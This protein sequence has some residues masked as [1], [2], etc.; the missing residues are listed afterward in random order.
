M[1]RA[2][3]YLVLVSV[4][5]LFIAASTPIT[6]CGGSGGGGPSGLDEDLCDLFSFSNNPAT[7]SLQNPPGCGVSTGGFSNHVFDEFGRVLSFDFDIRCPSGDTP[8]LVGRVFNVQW[9][10]LGEILSLQATINGRSCSL[11]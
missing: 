4:V 6:G 11:P 9:N 2:L 7:I 3:R 1:T 5:G 8:R 10:N